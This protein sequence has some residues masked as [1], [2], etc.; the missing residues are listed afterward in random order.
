MNL[1]I[2]KWKLEFENFF[3]YWLRREIFYKLLCV[4]GLERGLCW[5]VC[6]IDKKFIVNYCGIC[7]DLCKEIYFFF[8]YFVCVMFFVFMCYFFFLI[9]KVKGYRFLFKRE[10][11]GY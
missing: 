7:G 2:R 11:I 8:F 10:F 5:S 6:L 1:V 9:E 3:E 4:Y